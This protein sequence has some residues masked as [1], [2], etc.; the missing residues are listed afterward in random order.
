V[1]S[2]RDLRAENG[3][4]LVE[5]LV[6]STVL[7]IGAMSAISLIERANQTTVTTRSR[8]GATNLAREVVEA[9]RGV[10][11]SSLTPGALGGLVQGNQP[12][13]ADE[14]PAVGWQIRRRNFT[15]T[16]TT[17]LCTMDDGRD[18]G[19]T[20]DTGSFCADSVAANS[21]DPVTGSVDRSPEDYK[22][23]RIEAAWRHKGVTRTVHQTTI[24]NNPGS[25]GG[26]AVR[27]L[28]LGTGGGTSTPGWVYAPTTSL[29][30]ALTTSRTP[31]TLRWLVDGSAQGPITDGSGLSWSF[32]WDLGPADDPAGVG[33]G[34]YL[35]GA[36]AFDTYGI[37]G[38]SR[39]LTVTINRSLPDKVQGFAG[40]RIKDPSDSTR[41]I[42][43]L[44]WLAVSER[45]IIG[46]EV[47]RIGA[48]GTRTVVCA[49]QEATTCQ[50]LSAPNDTVD[51]VVRAYDYASP[52]VERSGPDSDVLTVT[53]ANTAPYPP[54]NLTL[55]RNA[56]GTTTL[57]WLARDPADPDLGDSIDFYRVYRDGQTFS[58]RYARWDDPSSTVTF[59]DSA[60]NGETHIYWVTAVDTH[61][62]ES[63]AVGPV[64]G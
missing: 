36:E 4:T 29:S 25:A 57:Q 52:G 14:S 59:I 38:P 6:A 18:G 42:V 30:F 7:L 13:L 9:V 49:R 32:G 50:D 19:G 51:Y 41:E 46:Y 2:L 24:I 8:E 53:G 64:S 16:V 1:R 62:G 22:R 31:A 20:Q 63:V 55:T 33:D 39:S 28:T 56:D 26:P 35:V 37:A 43:D 27:T 21:P 23:I 61:L 34:V 45:D 11:F 15:Y 5:I 44:E 10:P 40:G 60:T 58:D 17:S 48:D 3:F 12:Q 54:A 47:L